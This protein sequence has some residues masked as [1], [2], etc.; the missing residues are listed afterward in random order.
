M[1]LL[2]ILLTTTVFS[3]NEFSKIDNFLYVD[4]EFQ[5]WSNDSIYRFNENIQLVSIKLNPLSES[6]DKI[7]SIRYV[8]NNSYN[9]YLSNGSGDVYDS[10]LK[11][12]DNTNN[13]YFYNNSLSFIHDDTI[14]KFGGYGLWTSFKQLIYFD[15]NYGDWNYFNLKKPKNFEGLFSSEIVKT[16]PGKY[17]VYGGNKLTP[18][19]SLIQEPNKNIYLID[20]KKSELKY[21][22]TSTIDFSGRKINFENGTSLNLKKNFISILDWKNN[23]IKKYKTN[24]THRVSQ[25]HNLFMSNGVIYYIEKKNNGYILSSSETDISNLNIVDEQEILTTTYFVQYIIFTILLF[26][27]FIFY[28]LFKDFNKIK[29]HKHSIRYRFVV[30]Q[31]DQE[32]EEILTI[33]LK[34]R[35]VSTNQLFN[36]ISS[37]ELHP[38]HIYRLIPE[39]MN[40][41]SKTIK[42]VTRKN[43]EV[44]SISKNEKD[45]RI[46]EYRLNPYYR[47][48][49]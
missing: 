31:I 35:K 46:K 10:T 22:G 42:L 12:I 9:Y 43:E 29:I 41:I 3:Q 13:S 11:R 38:N 6:S 20:F 17:L 16:E 48:K 21:I 24:F 8:G 1:R 7:S 15:F 27:L 25:D 39:V 2:L 32:K 34:D 36:I 44:F 33:L 40:D 37:K 47:V 49:N 26:L 45:R 30:F 19:N 28:Y 5:I 14:Y 23:S 4:D 18:E